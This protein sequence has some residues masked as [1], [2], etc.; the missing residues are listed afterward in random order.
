MSAPDLAEPLR[1]WRA[2]R[3]T[4]TRA[5]LRLAS[6]IYDDTWQPGKP[7]RATCRSA[8]HGAPGARCDCGI[9]ASRSSFD[10]ARY[11]IG[12][13]DPLVVHRV[14]GVVRLWGVVFEGSRGWRAEIAY[15]ERVWVPQVSAA[16]EIA[17]LLGVYGIP[18]EGV[19]A[20]PGAGV[21]SEIAALT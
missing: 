1:G 21:A 16:G 9:Y 7:F 15:P 14:V 10:A 3:V 17:R 18:V 2:W 6:V 8:P 5:G 19:A 4:E 11:L 12:R 13:N 20:R